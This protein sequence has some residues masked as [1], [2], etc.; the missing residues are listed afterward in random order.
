[1]KSLGTEALKALEDLVKSG[2]FVSL[3]EAVLDAI[4]AW[5]QSADDPDQRLEAIRLRVRR[6]ID[7]PRPDISMEELVAALDEMM[8]EAQRVPGRVAS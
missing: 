2:G 5:H 1:M 4:E 3:D 7:D 6:S 8:A